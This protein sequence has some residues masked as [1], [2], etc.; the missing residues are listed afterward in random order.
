MNNFLKNFANQLIVIF[1]ILKWFVL[2]AFS[3]GA[4][5]IAIVL[6]LTLLQKGETKLFE[7]QYYYFFLPIALFLSILIIRKFSPQSEG[8][9]TEKVIEAI[10]KNNGKIDLKVFPIKLLA[11]LMT[12]LFGGSAGKVGPSAQLGAS[13]SLLIAKFIKFNDEDRK[14]FL[15]CGISAGFAGV[16]GTPLAGAFFASELIYIGK[17][18]YKNF[19]PSLISAY[20]SF[21]V[22]S[23][24][25]I[26]F[27]FHPINNE[28]EF[29]FIFILKMFLFGFFIGF[30]AILFILI[31]KKLKKLFENLKIFPPLK[32]L[33]GGIIIVIFVLIFDGRRYL[34]IGDNVVM[35]SLLGE[36]LPKMSFLKKIFTTSMTLSSGGSGGIVSPI[37]FIGASAGNLWA[38][39]F[40]ESITLY[41]AIGITAFL[42]ACTNAPLAAIILTIELFGLQAGTYGA[43]A[44]IISYLVVGH[45]SIYQIESVEKNKVYFAD[46]KIQNSIYSFLE[47]FFKKK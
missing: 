3:G 29:S 5:G 44:V 25:G 14:R 39:L 33:I 31:Y 19:L 43:V 8:Q 45:L 20:T 23:H 16:L 11:T 17:L 32:G 13:F 4:T 27:I 10:R 46:E 28:I 35:V 47:K 22:T 21:L 7:F 12:I 38:Q 37:L 41:S 1:T 42:S 15:L 26:N 34:G 40:N 36:E 2:S 30:V 6:F 24:F 18:S 9:G